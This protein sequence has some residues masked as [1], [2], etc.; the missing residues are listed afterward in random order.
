MKRIGICEIKRISIDE[1]MAL[2]PKE[3]YK[4]KDEGRVEFMNK[5]GQQWTISINK[6]LHTKSI[7]SVHINQIL[8][9]D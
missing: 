3:A 1:C 6:K 8:P 9:T 7:C 5:F 4:L 2:I